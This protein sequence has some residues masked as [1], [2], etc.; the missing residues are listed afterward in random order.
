MWIGHLFRR[1]IDIPCEATPFSCNSGKFPAIGYCKVPEIQTGFF[2][3]RMESTVGNSCAWFFCRLLIWTV[4]EELMNLNCVTFSRVH[5]HPLRT[6]ISTVCLIR[7]TWIA[8]D[9]L[10]MVSEV[11][12]T[13]SPFHCWLFSYTI[14]KVIFV[15]QCASVWNESKCKNLLMEVS[16]TCMKMN[17]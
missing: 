17:L 10:R 1:Y 11:K 14:Q 8:E 15:F 3:C 6:W 12:F 5:T 13:N 4:M 16:L 9:L 2:F 7:W